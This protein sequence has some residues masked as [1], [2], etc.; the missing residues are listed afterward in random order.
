MFECP[1]FFSLTQLQKKVFFLAQSSSEN[2]FMTLF[3]LETSSL[4][5]NACYNSFISFSQNFQLTKL[6]LEVIY[7]LSQIGHIS[8]LVHL[9]RQSSLYI[10]LQFRVN[11]YSLQWV[12][13]TW[14]IMQTPPPCNALQ[15]IF[16]TI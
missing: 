13:M 12:K 9:L 10:V 4:L 3:S 15:W 5:E 11:P 7:Q 6:V 14:N 16:N 8:K 1:S 2:L